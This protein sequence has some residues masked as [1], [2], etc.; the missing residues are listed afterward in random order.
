MPIIKSAKKRVKVA[1]KAN[2]RNVKTKRTL[3][4][5]LKAFSAAVASANS[6]Q[7]AKAQKDAMSALDVAVK[8]A[9]IH[10]NKAARKKAQLA[11]QAKTGGYKPSKTAAKKTATKAAAKKPAA[12]KAAPK[13][14]ATKTASK[15]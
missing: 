9:V 3:R 2:L 7:I 10:K 5:S 11:A 6:S 8:K 12:K 14:T 1:T 15:K 13:K 4:E